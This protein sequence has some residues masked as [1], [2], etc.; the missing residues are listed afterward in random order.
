MRHTHEREIDGSRWTVTEFS[1]TEGLRILTRLVKLLGDSAAKAFGALPTEGGISVLDAKID[2]SMLGEAIG[3]LANR[4][5]EDEVDELVK[6]L[7]ANTLIDGK[8]GKEPAG[9]PRFDIVFQGRYVTLF[10]VLSF[11]LEVNY[12]IPLSDLL[13]ATSP[14]AGA[15]TS[16]GE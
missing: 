7:L 11:V 2:W 13:V 12:R 10:K 6:R 1:A 5:D 14:I 15:V 8:A 3:G 16:K 4:L 9:G